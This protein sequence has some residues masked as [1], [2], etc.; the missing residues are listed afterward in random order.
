V[1]KAEEGSCSTWY[2]IPMQSCMDPEV[3]G[4]F[5]QILSVESESELGCH[6]LRTALGWEMLETR[7]QDSSA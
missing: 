3:H 1:F 4:D 5:D 6:G 2:K 7:S